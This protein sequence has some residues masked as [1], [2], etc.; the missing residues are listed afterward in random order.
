[1]DRETGPRGGTQEWDA[2]V[3]ERGARR[4]IT[5]GT[6]RGFGCGLGCGTNA[7]NPPRFLSFGDVR[8]VAQAWRDDSNRVHRRGALGN[9]TPVE[10][11][12]L[13]HQGMHGCRCFGEFMFH[14]MRSS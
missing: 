13:V 6:D 10:F 5:A 12:R 8:S 1:M 11:A 9:R 14:Q 7:L 3:G 2:G 4:R